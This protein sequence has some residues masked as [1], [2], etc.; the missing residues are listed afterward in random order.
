[1]AELHAVGSQDFADQ[2][3]AMTVAR[4]A[5]AAHQCDPVVASAVEQPRNRRPK[6]RLQGHRAIERVTILV[7]VLGLIR[8]ATE[9]GSEEKV[10]GLAIEGGRQILAIE[11]RGKAGIRVRP[12]IDE[13]LDALLREHGE[14]VI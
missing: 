8:T 14:E 11:L 6:P 13:E 3:P 12:N 7:V 2:E 10:A 5:L 4:V 1:M 9:L